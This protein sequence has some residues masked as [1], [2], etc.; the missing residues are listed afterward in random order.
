MSFVGRETAI[1]GSFGMDKRDIEDLL[2][3]I[4]RGR[5]DLSR[6]ITQTYAL[7]EINAALTRLASKDSGVVR[8]VVEPWR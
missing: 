7:D 4:A 8:L 1:L 2:A 3:L 5:L 6:S